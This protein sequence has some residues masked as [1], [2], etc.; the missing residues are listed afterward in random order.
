MP[1]LHHSLR[2]QADAQPRRHRRTHTGQARAGIANAPAP[3]TDLQMLEHFIAVQ[4]AHRE[5]HQGQWIAAQGRHVAA[6]D[7]AQRLRPGGQAVVAVAH[8]LDQQHIELT[9]AILAQQRRPQAA[10]DL[11]AHPWVGHYKRREQRHQALGGKIFGHAQAQ[12]AVALLV[13][14][15]IGGFF[16]ECQ[17]AP[18]IGQQALALDR[19]HH[20]ALIPVEQ[21]AADTVFQA[22]QLLAD[23][24]LG[25]VQALGGAGEIRAIHDGDK[26][27]QQHGIEHGH[28]HLV[29]HWLAWLYLISEY[30]RRWPYFAF[31]ALK[32]GSH[33]MAHSF[34]NRR[35]G[36]GVDG[37]E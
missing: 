15:H 3:A 5:R 16:V 36:A 14:Q 9:A 27:A 1:G 26:T 19:R 8:L 34:Q 29:C 12:H 23:R 21:A 24:R 28:H 13:D 35:A 32:R 2:Q 31:I 20:P 10:G 4:A 37:G 30:P 11:Q 33:G 17:D 7:P 18:R 25:Q 6:V 22:A